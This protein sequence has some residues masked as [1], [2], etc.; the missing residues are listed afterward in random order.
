MWHLLVLFCFS[1]WL[2]KQVY[3]YLKKN[4]GL[5][6]YIFWI[7]WKIFRNDFLR[8]WFFNFTNFLAWTFCWLKKLMIFY[9]IYSQ[10][11]TSLEPE[12]R[13]SRIC[14]NLCLLLTALFHFIHNNVSPVLM[15]LTAGQRSASELHRHLRALSICF[16]LIVSSLSLMVILWQWFT[17][18]KYFWIIAFI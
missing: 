2:C 11:L 15:S 10:G 13:F 16:F 8:N 7:L 5:S 18:G 6:F 1:F 3:W 14:K 9:F 12:K 17:I 4:Y